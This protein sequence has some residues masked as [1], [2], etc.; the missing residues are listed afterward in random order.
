MQSSSIQ[1]DQNKFQFK[2]NTFNENYA[3]AKASIVQL[4][5]IRRIH[6]DS[7]TYTLNS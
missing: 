6:I 3:G 4:T 7:D 1:V 2:Q 5:N